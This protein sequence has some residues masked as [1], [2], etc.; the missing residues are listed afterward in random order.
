MH[1]LI[2]AV[3]IFFVLLPFGV[4]R[5]ECP[6]D[7]I[8]ACSNH[9]TGLVRITPG[10]EKC[11]NW[12]TPLSWNRT[13]VPGKPGTEGPPGPA[14]A[15]GPR[16]EPGP[17]GPAGP[18]GPSGSAGTSNTPA[19]TSDRID[20][21]PRGYVDFLVVVA[22][23]ASFIVGILAIGLSVV[24]YRSSVQFR[25]ETSESAREVSRNADRLENLLNRVYLDGLSVM[26]DNMAALRCAGSPAPDTPSQQSRGP[27]HGVGDGEPA[28]GLEPAPAPVAR[29]PHPPGEPVRHEDHAGIF[30]RLAAYSGRRVEDIFE[31]P[32][33]GN[34]VED[35]MGRYYTKLVENLRVSGKVGIDSAGDLYV[36][37]MAPQKE[38][39]EEALLH[40]TR[41]GGIYAA[42][43]TQ[44][45]KVLC[46]SN[47]DEFKKKLVPTVQQFIKRFADVKVIFMS[48]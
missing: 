35:L 31:H 28:I 15:R 10:P 42:I 19:H 20:A 48:H 27:A 24:F 26:K 32:E 16:G 8:H 21:T 46:F 11:R 34:A 40:I 36:F 17:P 22:A 2:S 13:G 43:L 41:A 14:G 30:D 33:L 44:G 3:A 45:E 29:P 39:V 1:R 6:D 9:Q 18:Q 7:V 25:H 37:G 47:R 23:L 5:G 12:E 38:T 4:A